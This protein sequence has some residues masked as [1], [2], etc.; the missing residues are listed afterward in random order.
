MLLRKPARQPHNTPA[1]L[2]AL[3]RAR[4]ATAANLNG[5]PPNTGPARELAA[6]A[7]AGAWEGA[8]ISSRSLMPVLRPS[9]AHGGAPQPHWQPEAHALP[10]LS[11]SAPAPTAVSLE[12][13]KLEVHG[14]RDSRSVQADVCMEMQA[15]KVREGVAAAG[16]IANLG[17]QRA[18]FGAFPPPPPS[19]SA[20][21]GG[22][23]EP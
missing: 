1:H 7:A 2:H 5:T 9:T 11:P 19:A 6:P 3:A 16:G 8:Q 22:A 14:P 21:R 12:G 18:R 15:A 20:P 13:V 4:S 23:G 17:S 10:S